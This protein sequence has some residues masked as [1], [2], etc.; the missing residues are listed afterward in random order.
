MNIG[1]EIRFETGPVAKVTDQHFQHDRNK[2]PFMV[3]TEFIVKDVEL[4]SEKKAVLHTYLSTTFFMIQ[5]KGQDV[6][7]EQIMKPLMEKI[8]KR[9]IQEIIYINKILKSMNPAEKRKMPEKTEK[10]DLCGR[11]FV[12][13]GGLKT[14]KTR[15]HG[16]KTKVIITN[17]V[18]TIVRS[19]SV[20][21]EQC[22]SPPPKKVTFA[23]QKVETAVLI[24][25]GDTEPARDVPALSVGE[26]SHQDPA[27]DLEEEEPVRVVEEPLLAGGEPA[28]AVR[29][30][31][32][33]GGELE[34]GG[35]IE[36]RG[37]VEAGGEPDQVLQQHPV[38]R[39]TREPGLQMAE[40][41]VQAQEEGP[42]P[43]EGYDMEEN[44]QNQEEI[45]KLKQLIQTLR[46][47]QA[48]KWREMEED[49]F[50]NYI[51]FEKFKKDSILNYDAIHEEKQKINDEMVK[52]QSENDLKVAQLEAELKKS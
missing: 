27:G 35:E 10:C 38:I 7:H 51:T 16:P 49:K 29:D 44:R 50:K 31:F 47:Q 30:L 40:G 4:K 13:T 17:T 12:G 20:K 5:G 43:M 46:I 25:F 3:K 23:P 8:M 33:A 41:M 48:L 26:S 45:V 21:S 18:S 36:A 32:Q 11:M 42:G 15:A 34:A 24:D 37:E 14:H 52:Q 1:D 6:F 9:S 2:V 28:L 19:D 39:L 22:L